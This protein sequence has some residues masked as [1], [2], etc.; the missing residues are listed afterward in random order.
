VEI[1]STPMDAARLDS[2]GEETTSSV[3]YLAVIQF[4]FRPLVHVKGLYILGASIPL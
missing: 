1:L 2:G 4:G 3:R